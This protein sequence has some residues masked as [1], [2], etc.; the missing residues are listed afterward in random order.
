MVLGILSFLRPKSKQNRKENPTALANTRAKNVSYK[1]PLSAA[2]GK[3]NTVDTDKRPTTDT[4]SD[5][6]VKDQPRFTPAGSTSKRD[7]D[8]ADTAITS[9][10]QHDVVTENEKPI[11]MRKGVSSSMISSVTGIS[12]AIPSPLDQNPH[13]LQLSRGDALD[14][15]NEWISRRPTQSQPDF[16][17]ADLYDSAIVSPGSINDNREKEIVNSIDTIENRHVLTTTHNHIFNEYLYETVLQPI[18]QEIIHPLETVEIRLPDTTENMR[19]D[20][21]F[22]FEDDTDQGFEDPT[23]IKRDILDFIDDARPQM[24]DRDI[25]SEDIQEAPQPVVIRHVVKTVHPVIEKVSVTTKQHRYYREKKYEHHL[26]ARYKKIE[27][28]PSISYD[29]WINGTTSLPIGTSQNQS[30]HRGRRD[31]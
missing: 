27:V 7:R 31:D 17:L 4:V 13:T 3:S 9:G 21:F 8:V 28:M 26:P 18:K 14:T 23:K 19:H 24:S 22:G 11:E 30:I 10:L 6:N 15:V 1:K 29:E 5:E 16:S 2:A 20:G 12:T 25:W